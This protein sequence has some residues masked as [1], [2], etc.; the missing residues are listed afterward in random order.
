MDAL[1]HQ[2]NETFQLWFYFMS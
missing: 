1:M 2:L